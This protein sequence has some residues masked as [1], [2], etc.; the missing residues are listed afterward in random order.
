MELADTEY[1]ELSLGREQKNAL[2]HQIISEAREETNQG[3]HYGDAIPEPKGTIINFHTTGLIRNQ[4]NGIIQTF[5]VPRVL[6]DREAVINLMPE[7]VALQLDQLTRESGKRPAVL[8][9]SRSGTLRIND[10]G[11]GDDAKRSSKPSEWLKA[12]EAHILEV[13]A[14]Q[15]VS[16]KRGMNCSMFQFNSKSDLSFVCVRGCIFFLSLSFLF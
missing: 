2:L 12:Q 1:E 8:D 3:F 10:P 4:V 14:T 5:K 7:S 13:I 16:D 9:K 6:I 11:G 15:E